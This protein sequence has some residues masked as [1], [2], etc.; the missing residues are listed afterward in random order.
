MAQI[1]ASI[2]FM[3]LLVTLAVILEQLVKAHW[4]QIVAALQGE[5]VRQTRRAQSAGRRAAA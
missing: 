2:F 4:A 5:P 3:A 1:L